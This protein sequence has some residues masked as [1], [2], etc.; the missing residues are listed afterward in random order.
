VI[1]HLL[2]IKQI[3]WLLRNTAGEAFV[4]VSLGLTSGRRRAED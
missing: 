1:D 3:A 4:I 2:A